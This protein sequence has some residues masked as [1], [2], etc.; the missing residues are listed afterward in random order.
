M[1]PTHESHS[2]QAW[3]Q[4]ELPLL[5]SASAQ[6]E[7][8]AYLLHTALRTR[9]DLPIRN[10]LYAWRLRCVALGVRPIGFQLGGG[11]SQWRA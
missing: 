2:A 10:T 1:N 6:R 9:A 4:T 5:E 3:A 11:R 8:R 7:R